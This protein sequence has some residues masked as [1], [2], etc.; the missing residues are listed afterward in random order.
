MPRAGGHGVMPPGPGA[1]PPGPGVFVDY[2]I[3]HTY[4]HV[5]QLIALIGPMS[6]PKSQSIPSRILRSKWPG[7][8][9]IA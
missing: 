7:A 1:M 8:Y 9:N 6:S 3:E 5:T 2:F 4:L